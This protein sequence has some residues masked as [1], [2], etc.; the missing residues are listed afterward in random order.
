MKAM[1]EMPKMLARAREAQGKMQELHRSMAARQF[2]GRDDGGLVVATV[3]GK[4]ELTDVEIRVEGV[5]NATLQPAVVAAVAEAQRQAQAAL[6]HE[7][8][9][10]ARDAGLPENLLQSAPPA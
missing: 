2:T 9:R 10:L 3:N 4:L 8:A 6:A 5:D 1:A 7:M